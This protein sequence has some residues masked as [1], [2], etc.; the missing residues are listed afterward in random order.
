MTGIETLRERVRSAERRQA[1]RTG[2]DEGPIA[3][4][5]QVGELQSLV[6]GLLDAINS[7]DVQESLSRRPSDQEQVPPAVAAGQAIVECCQ[8]IGT[9]EAVID[10][11][12]LCDG[13]TVCQALLDIAA[14]LGASKEVDELL[15]GATYQPRRSENVCPGC[16]YWPYKCKCGSEEPRIPTKEESPTGLHQRYIVTKPGEPVDRDAMYFVLRLDSAGDD[17]QHVLA[18]RRAAVAYADTIRMIKHEQL[19]EVAD[20]LCALVTKLQDA[21]AEEGATG[22]S[23]A[24]V[25]ELDGMKFCSRCSQPIEGETCGCERPGLSP[26]QMEALQHVRRA[27]GDAAQDLATATGIPVDEAKRYIESAAEQLRADDAAAAEIETAARESFQTWAATRGHLQP[28]SLDSHRRRVT[29]QDLRCEA[30]TIAA[31]L[32]P[33]DKTAFDPAVLRSELSKLARVVARSLSS[34]TSWAPRRIRSTFGPI[35]RGVQSREQAAQDITDATGQAIEISR[36]QVDSFERSLS[37]GSAASGCSIR[38]AREHVEKAIAAHRAPDAPDPTTLS[39]TPPVGGCDD[40]A[41]HAGPQSIT[42]PKLHSKRKICLK[43][44]CVAQHG[45]TELYIVGDF[46][47]LR[48]PKCGESYDKNGDSL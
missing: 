29:R 12:W 40:P 30:L 39:Q 15:K 3:L 47:V 17:T 8:T 16:G 48:C 38:D 1:L 43:P 35:T 2:V 31:A 6:A 32:D 41:K 9:S 26:E 14:T 18:C 24:G 42:K 5:E 21:D 37:D 46:K 36:R 45:A 25:L 28:E 22:V 20:D 27:A 13:V 7:R 10:T 33:S 44:R 11:I 19:F 34:E 4:A 23:P